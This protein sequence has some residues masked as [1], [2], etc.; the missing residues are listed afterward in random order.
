MAK[1]N[2]KSILTKSC[3]FRDAELEKVFFD[4]EFSKSLRTFRILILFCGAIYFAIAAYDYFYAEDIR[5]FWISFTIRFVVFLFAL[6]LFFYM[7]K[8]SNNKTVFIL[9][10]IFEGLV[11]FSY[12]LVLM[13]FNA[14]GYLSQCLTIMVFLQALALLPNK[15]LNFM[16]MALVITVTFFVLT[17]MYIHAIDPSERTESIIMLSIS[18]LFLGIFTYRIQAA[19]RMQFFRQ[20]ELK[21]MSETDSL[22]K[23]MNRG[24]FNAILEYW[25]EF[26]NRYASPFSLIYFDIDN[27]K[28][29]ND[30]FGHSLGDTVLVTMCDIVRN[31]A[32]KND[33]L[34]RCGGEEFAL[35]LPQ[36]DLQEAKK[37][38]LRLCDHTQETD[39]GVVGRVTASFGVVMH[40]PSEQPSA[41]LHRADEMMYNA[42]KAGKNRVVSE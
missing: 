25:C 24:K 11:V 7:K 37:M 4:T 16:V 27:F 40:R 31:I 29:I 2:K 22:T 1:T 28:N 10:T 15:W 9:I 3:E 42:K 23:S 30:T 36:T 6:F 35:L 39:F 26:S 32:R 18:I 17:P 38:A 34:A 41:I 21:Q 13:A 20:M 12:F 14:Q 8:S 33:Q 5:D 19:R